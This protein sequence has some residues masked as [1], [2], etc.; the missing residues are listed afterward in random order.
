M[1]LKEV[2]QIPTGG[3]R[4]LLLKDSSGEEVLTV[5]DEELQPA[6]ALSAGTV[7]RVRTSGDKLYVLAD[8]KLTVYDKTLKEV[9]SYELDD[10][11]SDMIIIGGSAYLLCFNT[12]QQVTL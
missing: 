9:G 2:A 4:A 8:R 7:T 10:V 1:F 11:Y 5:Y 12:V 6:A 3:V